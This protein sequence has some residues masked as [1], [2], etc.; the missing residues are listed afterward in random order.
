MLLLLII[1]LI[2]YVSMIFMTKHRTP[3]AFI[4]AGILLSIGALTSLFDINAAFSKF[5]GEIVILIIVLSLYTEAFN[6]FGLINF[7]GYKFVK[8]S[9]ENKVIIMVTMPLLIYA[10]SLF[11]NNLTVVLLFSYMALYLAIEYQL[12]TVPLLVS[13]IIGSNIGGAALPWADTPA[14]ILTLYTDFSLADFLGKLFVPCLF[15]AAA[16]SLYSYIWHKY[17]SPKIRMLPFN[18]KPDVDWKRLKPVLVLFVLYIVMISAGPFIKVSIAFI[19][20]FF[21]GI[22]LLIDKRDPMDDLNELP[23]M[24][25]IAFIIALF[26]IGGVLEYSGILI[27]ITRYIIGIT[28]QNT[29]LLAL[30]VLFMAFVFSTILS[31][32]PAAATLLPICK[33]LEASVPFKLIYAALALGILAGS[34]MLPWSATGG[35]VLFSQINKFLKF[36]SQS[37]SQSQSQPRPQPL[38]LLRHQIQPQP[39]IQPQRRHQLQRYSKNEETEHIREVFSLKSYLSFSVPFSLFILAAS[40]VYIVLFISCIG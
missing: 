37:Q 40:A 31:A 29:Y 19:S 3:V 18:K 38:P 15:Y 13:I 24:D 8:L 4:G 25:S 12:P 23:I 7:I 21:G 16:L 36:Y 14:V 22:L 35:P 5:P 6:R 11:M 9:K 2:V 17:F 28:G 26:L 1:T 34:G 32:G 27:I 30:A 10:T 33:A 39:L 20:L